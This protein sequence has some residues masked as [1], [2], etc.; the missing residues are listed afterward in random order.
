MMLSNFGQG[1]MGISGSYFDP[2][3]QI[4]PLETQNDPCLIGIKDLFSAT[5]H[6]DGGFSRPQ[7]EEFPSIEF[8][9]ILI[10]L[11]FFHKLNFLLVIFEEHMTSTLLYS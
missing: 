10:L 7:I 11:L 5:P 9:N 6:L 4:F 2:S 8:I 1:N 3:K